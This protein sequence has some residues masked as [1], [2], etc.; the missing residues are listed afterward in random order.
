MSVDKCS[1]IISAAVLVRG[2]GGYLHFEQHSWIGDR[3]P[4][5]S[6][7]Y[8]EEALSAVPIPRQIPGFASDDII[9]VSE[10]YKWG[11]VTTLPSD[12]E[13]LEMLRIA[14]KAHAQHLL[15]M[16]GWP[17]VQISI[18]H[19][20]IPNLKEEWLNEVLMANKKSSDSC[21]TSHNDQ[22]AIG[23]EG[24]DMLTDHLHMTELFR[25]GGL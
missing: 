17:N 1:F 14:L 4:F 5:S 3:F 7:M 8:P 16:V 24:T 2:E 25:P 21:G 10:M 11:D 18:N 9:K 12:I 22:D 13:Y 19:I 20:P 15:R 23:D 6:A